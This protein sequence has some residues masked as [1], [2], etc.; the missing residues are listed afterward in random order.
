M[1]FPVV[2]EIIFECICSLLCAFRNGYFC[3]IAI[4]AMKLCL[5]LAFRLH[6]L[7]NLW[8]LIYVSYFDFRLWSNSHWHCSYTSAYRCVD[9]S[10]HI[11]RDSIHQYTSAEIYT[12][13][14]KLIRKNDTQSF[15]YLTL[16]DDIH[17]VCTM[18]TWF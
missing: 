12:H 9:T 17:Y 1:P 7:E 15:L 13:E 3:E 4:I 6:L 11:W 10:L 8:K 14:N 5:Q 18:C 2:I 16:F